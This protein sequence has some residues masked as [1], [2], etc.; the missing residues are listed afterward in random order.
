MEAEAAKRQGYEDLLPVNYDVATVIDHLFAL[1]RV[2]EHDIASFTPDD[3]KTAC[4]ILCMT[5]RL[6]EVFDKTVY[7]ASL[8]KRAYGEQ[9]AAKTKSYKVGRDNTTNTMDYATARLQGM[10]PQQEWKR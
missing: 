2:S 6:D 8:L 7:V 1:H 5:H 3:I 10:L 4:S 9:A